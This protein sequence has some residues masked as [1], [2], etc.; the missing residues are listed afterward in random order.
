M[1]FIRGDVSD[2]SENDTLLK[3]IIGPNWKHLTGADQP[4]H[5]PGASPGYKHDE[6]WADIMRRVEER[7]K[8]KENATPTTP[9]QI[10]SET[11]SAINIEE[12]ASPEVT[13]PVSN[14]E[15]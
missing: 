11:E 5:S 15:N 7:R 9:S 4:V 10:A 2:G 6:Y 1:I 13:P 14:D 8:I 3:T 12:Q